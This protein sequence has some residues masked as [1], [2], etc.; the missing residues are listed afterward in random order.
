MVP[1]TDGTGK[2]K[3]LHVVIRTGV[4]DLINKS[5]FSALR[6]GE[7]FISSA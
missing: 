4:G 7:V 2:K 3:V 6:C 1:I 5:V